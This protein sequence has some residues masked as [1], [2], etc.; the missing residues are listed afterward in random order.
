M[1]KKW[2]IIFPITILLMIIY[3]KS[4]YKI[5][6]NDVSIIFKKT[7]SK[8]T[9]VKHKNKSNDIQCYRKNRESLKDIS[10][11]SPRKG[12]SIFFHETSCKSYEKGKLLISSRQACAVESAAKMNPNLDVYLLYSSPGLL[13]FEGDESDKF[14]EVLLEYKNVKIMHLDYGK[15]TKGTLVEDLY[16]SGKLEQSHFVVSHA[17][18]VLR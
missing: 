2:L 7:E 8:S 9:T 1:T 12:K 17:S 15:Y 14:L 13:K 16:T 18:D 3:S 6:N 5:D 4:I 11:I 10:Q